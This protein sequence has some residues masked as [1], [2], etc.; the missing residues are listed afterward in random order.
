MPGRIVNVL[1]PALFASKFDIVPSLF[2]PIAD[3]GKRFIGFLLPIFLI[4]ILVW[5]IPGL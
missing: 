5:R 1:D 2:V 3:A 4:P